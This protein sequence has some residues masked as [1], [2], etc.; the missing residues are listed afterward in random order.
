M[1]LYLL[2]H[3]NM[4][5]IWNIEEKIVDS[6]IEDIPMI[7]NF[8]KKNLL[9]QRLWSYIQKMH[10]VN[11]LWLNHNQHTCQHRLFLVLFIF[12]YSDFSINMQWTF[13]F[14]LF[15]ANRQFLID[16]WDWSLLTS[17]RKTK[18][19]EKNCYFIT[20]IFLI[21]LSKKKSWKWLLRF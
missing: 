17:T 7:I 3:F 4:H 9:L 6:A 11:G 15:S 5:L 16:W 20:Y 8:T 19:T 18:N 14:V 10:L 13:I 2:K 21:S 12:H 1:F